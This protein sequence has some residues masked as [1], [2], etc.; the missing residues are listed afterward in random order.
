M[1][2]VGNAEEKSMLLSSCY[3]GLL[4]AFH[5][6]TEFWAL[7]TRRVWPNAFPTYLNT[8]HFSLENIWPD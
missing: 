5:V 6:L 3:A 4:K 7:Y 1:V 2:I 8:D